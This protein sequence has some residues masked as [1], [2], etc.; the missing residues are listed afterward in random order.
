MVRAT[1]EVGG[2]VCFVFLLK[3][4]LPRPNWALEFGAVAAKSHLGIKSGQLLNLLPHL[5]PFLHSEPAPKGAR[6]GLEEG[7]GLE[8]E[9]EG[10]QG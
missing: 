8:R 5:F 10:P 9:P 1:S 7:S 3:Q 6:T 2:P 4:T